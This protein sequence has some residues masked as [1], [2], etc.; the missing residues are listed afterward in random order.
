MF[1]SHNESISTCT[2]SL[3]EPVP[4]QSS[5][6]AGGLIQTVEGGVLTKRSSRLAGM[7]RPKD[8]PTDSEFEPC[9]FDVCSL[10]SG[11]VK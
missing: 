4:V 6:P 11:F 1:S 5:S 10:C 8:Q 9:V 3:V 2:D 7:S